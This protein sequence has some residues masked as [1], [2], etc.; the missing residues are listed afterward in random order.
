MNIFINDF[1]NKVVHV[2]ST[3]GQYNFQSLSSLDLKD[4]PLS[5]AVH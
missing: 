3:D 4:R 2:L 5:L 1:E